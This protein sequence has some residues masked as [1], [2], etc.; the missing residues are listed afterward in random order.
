MGF[1]LRL[2]I[3]FFF[4]FLFRKNVL[5]NSSFIVKKE[6]LNLVISDLRAGMKNLL[7]LLIFFCKLFFFFN[8]K[9]LFR[10]NALYFSCDK[11]Y[12]FRFKYKTNFLG[13]D[14]FLNITFNIKNYLSHLAPEET[15]YALLP[16]MVVIETLSNLMRPFTLAIRIR[17]N[18]IAG[19]LLLVLVRGFLAKVRIIG[20]PVLYFGTTIL[21]L[22]ETI[23]I[24]I[25]AYIFTILISLYFSE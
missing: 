18:I 2:C 17:A 11:P 7:F 6:V 10:F 22:L 24:A 16:L 15:S 25:Q 20:F 13:C 4:F 12:K 8:D 1:K 21:I 14:V 23:V 9:Q 5:F 19:H 3:F